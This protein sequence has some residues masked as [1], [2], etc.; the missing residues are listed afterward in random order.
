MEVEAAKT[1]REKL[2]EKIY[3]I[4]NNDNRRIEEFKRTKNAATVL[5]IDLEKN[6]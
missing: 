1:M 5:S 4:Q 2:F 6:R 3:A